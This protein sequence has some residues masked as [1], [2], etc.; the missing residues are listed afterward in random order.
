[1]NVNDIVTI[2]FSSTIL[3]TIITSVFNLLSNKKRFSRKHK[4]RA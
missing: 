4:K 1:M 3:A 2:V